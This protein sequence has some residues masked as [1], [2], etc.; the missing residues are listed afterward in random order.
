M[1]VD[2][3]H[4]HTATWKGKRRKREVWLTRLG[5]ARQK[6]AAQHCLRTKSYDTGAQEISQ[7]VHCLGQHQNPSVSTQ[8]QK[9][10]ERASRG[11]AGSESEK[12]KRMEE[13]CIFRGE[14]IGTLEGQLLMLFITLAL[15]L[16]FLK[17]GTKKIFD[18]TIS[19]KQPL[20]LHLRI[21]ANNK[22]SKRGSVNY[23]METFNAK[24]SS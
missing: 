9:T 22:W 17:S 16:R 24:R 18:T 20:N 1:A 14:E 8:R 3:S 7:I 19:R 13:H 4:S 5:P 11:K 10:G 15:F 12:R 21:F 2:S 23:F 6:A